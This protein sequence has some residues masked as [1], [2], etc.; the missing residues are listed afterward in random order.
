MSTRQRREQAAAELAAYKEQLRQQRQAVETD[1]AFQN[2]MQ[3]FYT[4]YGVDLGSILMGSLDALEERIRK[5]E[6]YLNLDIAG[7]Q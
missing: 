2:A 5:I 7:N 1:A 6:R 4:D 3:Q